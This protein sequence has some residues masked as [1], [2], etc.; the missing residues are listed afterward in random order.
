[1]V[2]LR[3]FVIP[4]LI[5]DPFLSAGPDG[6][7]QNDGNVHRTVDVQRRGMDPGGTFGF[8]EIKAGMTKLRGLRPVSAAERRR[9]LV[10]PELPSLQI[11]AL[12]V[13]TVPPAYTALHP[14]CD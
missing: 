4:D 8:A 11:S 1:M 13:G 10:P 2:G 7:H 6:S 14:H 12:S 9:P 3:N 5:R